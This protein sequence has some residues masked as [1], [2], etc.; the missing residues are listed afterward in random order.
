MMKAGAHDYLMKD[1]LARLPE[2][3]KR[4]IR[5][6]Q[7][8]HQRKQAEI[9]LAKRERYLTVLVE[10]QRQLLAPCLNAHIYGQILQQLAAITGADRIY[11]VQ[12]HQDVQGNIVL[13]QK[14][15]WCH[16]DEETC[17][18]IS[19]VIFEEE[20]STRWLPILTQGDL[21]QGSVATFPPPEQVILK[22]YQ[23]KSL[24]LLPLVA[25]NT[26]F[27]FLEFDYC[28]TLQTCH[29]L[30]LDWLNSITGALAIAQ[31]R[32]QATQ[33]LA[34]LNQE[35]ETRVVQRTHELQESEA[36]L[37]ESQKFMET[38]LDTLPL[39]VFWKDK[40]SVFLGCNQKLAHTLEISKEEII[41]KT[42]FDICVTKSEAI[43]Y[44]A[45]DQLVI[46][47][48][49]PKL[50]IEEKLTLPNGK[51][52]WLETHKAPLKNW[53]GDIIGIVNILQN[54]TE[55][56]QANQMI[57]QQALRE[58]LLREITQSIGQSLDL[59]E[60]FDTA[61]QEIRHVIQADRVSVFKFDPDSMG[62]SG[63]FVA[64]SVVPG[65]PAIIG[66]AI[67]DHYFN[68]NYISHYAQGQYYALHDTHNND[69]EL[70]HPEIVTQFQIRANL[71]M[72]L[73]CSNHSGE[74]LWGLL[75]V[76]QCTQPRHWEQSDIDLTEQLAHQ[77]AIAIQKAN[78]FEQLQQELS[79][80]QQ[81]QQQ[82]TER[83]QQLAIF[84]EEL[85]RATRLKDEFLA[86]MSHELRTPLN[87]ILGMTEGLQEQVFGKINS[88]QMRA[89]ETIDRSG[90][91]LLDLINDILDV[92]KIESGQFNLDCSPV[93][94]SSLCQS[95]LAF[96]KQ[97]ALK[98]AI[99]LEIKMP[100]KLPDLLI[101][102]RRIRQVLIN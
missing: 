60:I 3:L 25:H 78:L 79:E 6:A 90:S 7:I 56:K 21:I 49:Q 74:Q 38:V 36:K 23:L 10:I 5:E 48:G 4:E 20:I 95:S 29:D 68:K 53:A 12:Q 63:R 28:Q 42:D 39:S 50:G 41:G 66:T 40:N 101:D 70:C 80:R 96:I 98:K 45:D 44:Q 77:L 76:H 32:E 88:E 72:P 69:L 43:S 30:E 73:L 86:N 17:L 82:L 19:S 14:A 24:V 22:T 87:A 13:C 83:N 97:Q 64:E 58:R 71:V 18:D 15:L 91:H 55:R 81:A 54:I 75:C 34:Q 100:H 16:G 47:S 26:F 65:F 31:E 67:P 52:I 59:Q 102:E 8:R 99:N 33:A 37:Q 85:V 27:G 2:V 35:L 89:L 51:E 84:N 9:L 93:S 61:C 94:V 1:N 11:F 92:A 62:N 46:S 57:H